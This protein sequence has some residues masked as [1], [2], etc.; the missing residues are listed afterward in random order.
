MAADGP[1]IL[2]SVYSEAYRMYSRLRCDWNI[3]ESGEVDQMGEW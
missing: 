3:N 2:N 1:P